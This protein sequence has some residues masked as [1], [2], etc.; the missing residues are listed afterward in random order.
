M[1][2]WNNI[3]F[4]LPLKKKKYTLRKHIIKNNDSWQQSET[5]LLYNS[6]QGTVKEKQK[7]H[8]RKIKTTFNTDNV[9][10]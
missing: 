2:L 4:Q 9:K 1:S 3:K 10:P 5:I 8:Y 6:I 7:T